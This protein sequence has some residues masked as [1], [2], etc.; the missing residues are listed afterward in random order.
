[1]KAALLIGMKCRMT[2]ADHN[3]RASDKCGNKIAATNAPLFL[4]LCDGKRWYKYRS[5]R[6]ASGPWLR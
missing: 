4:A 2:D 5:T 3:L 6:M 1:M